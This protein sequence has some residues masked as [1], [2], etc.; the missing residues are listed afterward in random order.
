MKEKLLDELKNRHNHFREITGFYIHDFYK[1][2][3]LNL[4]AFHKVGIYNIEN[5]V[6]LVKFIE[7]SGFGKNVNSQIKIDLD[8]SNRGVYYTELEI[9]YKGF[10]NGIKGN[11]YQS[12]LKTMFPYPKIESIILGYRFN[13]ND[14]F[15]IENVLNSITNEYLDYHIDV[16]ISELKKYFDT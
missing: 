14:R 3:I 2:I 4:S 5:E 8:K 15:E 13:Q 9:D 6:R 7:K 11:K 1:K 16:K 12:I 10:L